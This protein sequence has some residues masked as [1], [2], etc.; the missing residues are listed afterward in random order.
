[1][2]QV[3]TQNKP[4]QG[5]KEEEEKVKRRGIEGRRKGVLVGAYW[6][7]GARI[8]SPHSLP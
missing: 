4:V 3:D 6:E 5:Q 1:L 8:P 2:C 7:S